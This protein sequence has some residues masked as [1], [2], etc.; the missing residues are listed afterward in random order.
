M[1]VHVVNTTAFNVPD[2]LSGPATSSVNVIAPWMAIGSVQVELRVEGADSE[3]AF[4]GDLYFYLNHT[5]SHG[6]SQIAVLLNRVG[7]QAERLSGYDDEGFNV[8][9]SDTGS[10]G[11]VHTYRTALYGNEGTPLAGGGPL[12]GTWQ[13]DGRETDPDSVLS[14]D[15]R[16]A[17][18]SGFQGMDPNGTWTLYAED[19]EMGGASKVTSW[20]LTVTAV[21]EPAS[22]AVLSALALL[23]FALWKR[24]PT[25]A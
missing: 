9:F 16:T 14:G 8:T 18:L 5:D 6:Q 19:M 13:P 17:M 15:G 20:G 25:A 22:C 10:L 24:T 11:D 23:G 4:N 12:T 7:R 1:V 21:P 3:R 2:D